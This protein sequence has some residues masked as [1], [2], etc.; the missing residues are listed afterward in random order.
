MREAW[1]ICPPPE[2]D[3]SLMSWIERTGREYGMTEMA[4]WRDLEPE[5]RVA[6]PSL[7][8]PSPRQ[9]DDL[10]FIERVTERSRLPP[11]SARN[12]W[13]EATGWE[14]RDTRFRVY[15]PLCS[16]ADIRAG[17]EP[18][19][20]RCWQQSWYTVCTV[21]G[22]PLLLRTHATADRYESPWSAE[23]L[24]WRIGLLAPHRYRTI[25]RTRDLSF[26]VRLL[27][28]LIEIERAL[29]EAI[30]GIRPNRLLWGDLTSEEFLIVVEDVTTWSLTRFASV[31]AASSAEDLTTLE[32][33]EGYGI[34]GR[35]RRPSGSSAPPNRTCENTLR[36]VT[37]P[38]VRGAALW[39][40]HAFLASCHQ[41]A[42]DRPS[43]ATPQRRQ[44][45]R[46]HRASPSSREWLACRQ[47]R[48]PATYRRR[49]WIDVGGDP[50]LCPS[51]RSAQDWM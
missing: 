29:S 50:D 39:V 5:D 40:A 24:H 14:L 32:H 43:G 16:L 8:P 6:E 34:I 10:R 23:E 48:W 9:L 21:H 44:A 51:D 37:H 13:P 45:A 33:Q 25:T 27:G 42:S 20:R 22:C 28:S 46:L 26:R 3:E 30:A 19:G 36:D 49:W 7:A 2:L 15:C 41:S 4:L 47:D 31:A 1:P 35:Q 18:Y 17:R 12:L 38:I 11:T